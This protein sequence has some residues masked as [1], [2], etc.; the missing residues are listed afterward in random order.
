VLIQSYSHPELLVS[1][2]GDVY[3]KD[4]MQR[5]SKVRDHG[6]S[7]RGYVLVYKYAKKH[8]NVSLLSLV[9]ETHVKKAKITSND[10]V[11]CID[12][13]EYNPVASNLQSINGRKFRK[14]PNRVSKKSDEGYST[15][16]NGESELFC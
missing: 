11:E 14:K 16:M 9:F 2:D 13:D 8:K 3:L 4:T 7:T 12:G 6:Y 1:E 5:V 10:F 15:W